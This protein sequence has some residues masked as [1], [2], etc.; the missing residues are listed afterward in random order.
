M[1][2]GHLLECGFGVIVRADHPQLVHRLD[3]ALKTGTLVPL[4]QGVYTRPDLAGDAGVKALAL[5]R[6]D[7]AAV[8]TGQAA[9]HLIYPGTVAPAVVSAASARLRPRAGFAIE[10]RHVPDC[11]V[12]RRHGVRVTSPALTALDLALPEGASID[13]ALRRG[14]TLEDLWAAL[15]MCPH[16]DGNRERRRL[17]AESR[18]QPWSPA[19][20]VAHRALREAGLTGWRTNLRVELSPTAA[21]Y[22]DVAFRALRLGLEIDGWEH[23]SSRAA[24]TRDRRRDRALA[25]RNWTV[26]R[27]TAAEV[28][29][30]PD[31]FVAEVRALIRGMA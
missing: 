10:R 14:V 22:I 16:R 21:A 23:H 30:D 25:Q 17:L 26:T 13:D 3:H 6:A 4:F 11:L 12:V 28:L 15:R 8:V 31:G 2:L 5:M 24:F 27:F 29:D 1:D 18:D 7:P 9:R 19:E 20:R